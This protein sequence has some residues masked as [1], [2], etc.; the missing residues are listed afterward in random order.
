MRGLFFLTV[1][2]S[3]MSCKGSSGAQPCQIVHENLK[4]FPQAAGFGAFTKGGRGGTIIEVT[5]LDDNGPGSFRE[6]C[7]TP[8]RRTVIFKIGGN[9]KLVSII[10]IVDPFITI[11]GQTAP[12]DGITLSGATLVVSASETIIRGLRIRVGSEQIR[13]WDGIAILS[14]KDKPVTNVIVDH[15]TISWSI[16]ENV[17]TNGRRSYISKVTFSNNIISE[18]LND[19]SKHSKNLP[20][21]A[22]M[23]LNKSGV[24]SVSVLGNLFAHNKF[25]QPKVGLGVTAEIVNNVIYNWATKSTTIAPNSTVNVIGNFYKPGPDWN[26]RYR[27]ILVGENTTSDSMGRVFLKDNWGPGLDTLNIDEWDA[28]SGVRTWKVD[29]SLIEIGTVA[30]RVGVAYKQVLAQ[31]GAWPRDTHDERVVNDV[32]NGTGRILKSESEVGGVLALAS[33]SP[34]KDTDG[35]G[36]PDDWEKNQG[37]DPNQPDDVQLDQNCNNYPDLEDYLNSFFKN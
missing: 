34:V 15:C 7:M 12:G 24:D 6:A 36:L 37:L 1:L 23:L 30:Q 19:G 22:G 27:G 14:M 17:S 18:G 16:D 31:A 8:G 33:G 29:S 2:A 35:D 5:N 28:T 32:I 25:R 13:D 20:H 11:A 9:I 10:R 21:S 4:A 26:G 3:L